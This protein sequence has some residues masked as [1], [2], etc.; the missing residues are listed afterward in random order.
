[1]KGDRL[2]FMNED[3]RITRSSELECADD[4]EATLYAEEQRAGHVI[5]LWTGPRMVAKFPKRQDA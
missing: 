5:E 2:D 3:G 4:V 1:M